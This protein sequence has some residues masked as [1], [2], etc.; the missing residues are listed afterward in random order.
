M[1]LEVRLDGESQ[2]LLLD[3]LVEDVE[4]ALDHLVTLLEGAC[5]QAQHRVD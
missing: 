5:L 4:D 3:I 2:L 1:I